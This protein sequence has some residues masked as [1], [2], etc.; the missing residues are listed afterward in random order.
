MRD[1]A[2]DLARE[3]R[4]IVIGLD[5]ASLFDFGELASGP[6]DGGLAGGEEPGLCELLNGTATFAEVICRDPASRLHFL[7]A[8][9]DGEFNL[10]EFENVLDSLAQIYDFLIMI[11]P[12][13]DVT[14]TAAMLATK[15]DFAL[16]VSCA[17]PQNGQVLEA[18][19]GEVLLIG[20]PD[21]S[22]RVIGRNA[23]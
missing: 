22:P 6:D 23:A 5:P 11:A 10:H 1:F 12:P 14:D 19:A 15:A 21:P 16:L 4:S 18:G 20:L 2:R 17:G 3:G 13:L 8:G 9:R 7:R